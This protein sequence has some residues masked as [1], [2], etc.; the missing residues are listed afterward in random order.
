MNTG[1]SGRFDGAGYGIFLLLI[2]GFIYLII[3]SYNWRIGLFCCVLM[4]VILELSYRLSVR[5]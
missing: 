2:A 1:F 5:S 3:D 4:I